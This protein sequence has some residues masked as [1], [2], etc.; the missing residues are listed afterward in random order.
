MDNRA[1]HGI[2]YGLHDPHTD[3]LRYIGQ[4]IKSVELRLA[5]HLAP[6]ML[7]RHSYLYRWLGGLVK[8]G[9][10]PGTSVIVEAYD[11]PELD[12]LEIEHIAKA[13]RDGCRLVNMSDGGGGRFGYVPTDDERKRISESNRGK[14]ALPKTEAQKQWMARLMAG[15]RTNTLEHMAKLRALRIGSK[16]TAET[17]IRCGA[18]NI[19][20][21]HT[22]EHREAISAKLKGR[23]QSPEH[24]AKNSGVKHGMYSGVP[25]SLII[26]LRLAGHSKR[27]IARVVGVAQPT[28][29]RRLRKA[30]IP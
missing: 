9:L 22:Q 21:V 11:Q 23:K 18:A 29:Q 27:N 25:D 2:I 13:R 24:T 8:A 28:I 4:T 15:R 14:H 12:R 7:K 5:C 19:G 10:K 6:G 3:E 26:G 17:K 1:R 20:R 30:G 16:H